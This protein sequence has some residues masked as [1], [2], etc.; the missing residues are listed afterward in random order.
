MALG[1]G[2]LVRGNKPAV[3]RLRGFLLA[4]TVVAGLAVPDVA[5]AQVQATP[6]PAE[7]A[8]GQAGRVVA[9]NIP[10]QDLDSALTRLAD[11]A[12]IRLLFTSRDLAGKRTAGLAGSY[13]VDQ[14]LTTLLAGSGFTWRLGESNTVVLEKLGASSACG[15]VQLDPVRVEGQQTPGTAYCSIHGY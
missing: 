1:V 10:A 4:S 6:A 13:T 7:L 9:F 8:Q 15:P 14:A 2:M 3:A 11:Q 5:R 12:G